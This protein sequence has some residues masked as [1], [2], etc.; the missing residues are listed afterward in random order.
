MSPAIARRVI[1]LA[2]VIVVAVALLTTVHFGLTTM[3]DG[4]GWGGATTSGT[5]A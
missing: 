5:L 4:F 2:A 3:A 1:V